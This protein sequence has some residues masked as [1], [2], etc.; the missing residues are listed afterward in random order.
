M[1]NRRGLYGGAGLRGPL[2]TILI[3]CGRV[4]AAEP[5]IAPGIFGLIES[6]PA[7]AISCEEGCGEG[8]RNLRRGADL[9]LRSIQQVWIKIS[10]IIWWSS[11]VEG[12]VRGGSRVLG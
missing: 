3:V 6:D 11:M 7:T 5:Y 8:V 10:T 1:R 9:L 12:T 4:P 2:T